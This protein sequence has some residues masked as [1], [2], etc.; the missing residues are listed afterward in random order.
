MTL[1]AVD[2]FVVIF[3]TRAVEHN[4]IYGKLELIREIII[5]RT[6]TGYHFIF[7]CIN[8]LCII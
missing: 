6:L 2:S 3:E 1:L 4:S 5:F 7:I 8:V